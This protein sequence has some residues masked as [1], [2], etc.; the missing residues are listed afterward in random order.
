MFV[1]S[2]DVE[3]LAFTDSDCIVDKNWLTEL[4]KGFREYPEA[5]SCGGAQKL[6]EDATN[7]EK[8][9]FLFMKKAGFF[10]EY[11]RQA[12]DANITEVNHN[13]SCCV[14]YK[15]EVFLKEGGFLEGLWPGEDVELDYRLREKGYKLLFNP[16]AVIYHY[17][18][19]SLKSFLKM[20]D[21]YGRAQG[22]LVRKYGIFRKI[23]L[24]PFLV[25][26][27]LT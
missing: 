18:S 15:R 21:R 1:K 26:G 3:F 25:L 13:A 11:A 6:P 19:K 24:V 22:Y 9:V 5:V 17:R 12:K 23:Q 10:S 2:T 7:F 20:M 4:L 8:K 16:R 14:M 27:L